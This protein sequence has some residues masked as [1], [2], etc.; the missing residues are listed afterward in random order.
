MKKFLGKKFYCNFCDYAYNE[1]YKHVCSDIDDWCFT[2]YRR[3]CENQILFEMK[4]SICNRKFRNNECSQIHSDS[5]KSNCKIF[6]CFECNTILKRRELSPGIWETNK[7]IIFRHG[8]CTSRCSVCEQ[9]TDEEH[10]CFMKRVPF[11]KHV[12]KVVYLDFETD[13]SSGQHVPIYCFMSWIFQTSKGEERGSKEFDVEK[14]VS[15]DVGKFLFSKYF[16]GY[17]SH[18]T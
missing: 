17:N 6:N 15:Q 10:A 16:K 12:N 1:I 9:Y 2:C 11:K 18:C 5:A 14:N 3:T 4:C 13:F 7:D 8:N